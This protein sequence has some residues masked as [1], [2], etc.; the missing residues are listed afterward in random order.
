MSAEWIS[1]HA[2]GWDA[3]DEEGRKFTLSLGNKIIPLSEGENKLWAYQVRPVIDE[4]V[5][6]LEGKGLP[7]K[8]YIQ[9]IRDAIEKYSKK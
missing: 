6:V 5:G 4:Y 9:F 8:E 7:G 1:K 2:K 3:A